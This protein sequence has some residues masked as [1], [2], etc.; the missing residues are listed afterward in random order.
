[1]KNIKTTW[2]A[3]LNVGL[4]LLPWIVVS[5]ILIQFGQPLLG[6]FKK[7][8]GNPMR[9]MNTLTQKLRDNPSRNIPFQR[10]STQFRQITRRDQIGDTDAH[11]LRLATLNIHQGV[12]KRVSA[13]GKNISLSDTYIS[14]LQQTSLN[15]IFQQAPLLRKELRKDLNRVQ[16][17]T[18]LPFYGV[19][20]LQEFSNHSDTVNK[21]IRTYGEMYANQLMC[22]KMASTTCSR[23]F[24]SST[25]TVS[26][27]ISQ[28]YKGWPDFAENASNDPGDFLTKLPRLMEVY[29][30]LGPSIN[31]YLKTPP[32]TQYSQLKT[33]QKKFRVHYR[34]NMRSWYTKVLQS[35][36]IKPEDFSS[37]ISESLVKKLEEII[38]LER[39]I[40]QS[41]Q[42]KAML[43]DGPVQS[44][45]KK[46]SQEIYDRY[47]WIYLTNRFDPSYQS[48]SDGLNLLRELLSVLPGGQQQLKQ[49]SSLFASIEENHSQISNL[50]E[51]KKYRDLSE[52]LRSIQ[53]NHLGPRDP[54][55]WT[56]MVKNFLKQSM[57]TITNPQ[58][59]P[60][61]QQSEDGFESLVKTYGELGKIL[62]VEG[63]DSNW[64]DQTILA[65][66]SRRFNQLKHSISKHLQQS[67]QQNR[68][69]LRNELSQLL[70]LKNLPE[71]LQGQP[72]A[73]FFRAIVIDRLTRNNAKLYDQ[74]ESRIRENAIWNRQWKE[75][76]SHLRPLENR[77]PQYLLTQTDLNTH[78]G[79]LH[80]WHENLTGSSSIDSLLKSTLV[81]RLESILGTLKNKTI[82]WITNP[83]DNSP[84]NSTLRTI[85]DNLNS[86][87]KEASRFESFAVENPLDRWAELL[88]FRKKLASLQTRI[89]NLKKGSL[90]GSNDSFQQYRNQLNNYAPGRFPDSYEP[91]HEF[92]K[93]LSIHQAIMNKSRKIHN[94]A[95]G[96]WLSG[97]GGRIRGPQVLKP[98][99]SF[100]QS[101]SGRFN[102][103]QLQ[104]EI[105]KLRSE[106]NKK[107]NEW[108]ES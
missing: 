12:V 32:W 25:K 88:T 40:T 28:Y 58:W 22:K 9:E 66:K 65:M 100:L 103:P 70:Q 76:T 1:M 78:I 73:I 99:Q 85:I 24:S 64:V 63:L 61:N 30:L 29:K 94:S 71:Q 51:N 46:I 33:S 48:S 34:N 108:E 81:D 23:I 82:E 13:G 3:L 18:K 36:K 41:D 21:F 67:N 106:V 52:T 11:Q 27:H 8:L 92:Q 75:L 95:Q 6:Q 83:G 14:F 87:L 101:V 77:R 54:V 84:D 104:S 72:R 91:Q 19:R 16:S 7:F 44:R 60:T 45:R 102:T 5:G 43:R 93:I 10:I 35:T 86:A 42:L 97:W 37:P 80:R 31:E 98:W 57:G 4:I 39:I 90:F 107:I 96:D 62:K 74:F 69:A 20:G 47:Q 26:N 56:I 17:I 2:S 89:N 50:L 79:A 49:T 55:G 105:A 68:S 59:Q 53:Q 38:R 15:K